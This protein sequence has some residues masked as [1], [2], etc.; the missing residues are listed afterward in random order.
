[1]NTLPA[2]Q[3]RSDEFEV[4]GNDFKIDAKGRKV[5]FKVCL[6][7]I[8]DKGLT[9]YYVAVQKCVNG[10]EFGVGQKGKPFKTQR[11]AADTGYAIAADRLSKLD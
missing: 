10:K 6:W 4:I 5:Q 3:I 1:M 8:S 7:N 9:T 2:Q 11:A